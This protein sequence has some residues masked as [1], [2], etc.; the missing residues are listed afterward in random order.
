MYVAISRAK[1]RFFATYHL[2]ERKEPS[3]PSRFLQEAGIEIRR[4]QS[5]T[6]QNPETATR[7]TGR[8]GPPSRATVAQQLARRA[9]RPTMPNIPDGFGGGPMKPPSRRPAGGSDEGE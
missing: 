4:L 9:S 3:Q 7:K 8:A 5:T 6:S 2:G 1:E